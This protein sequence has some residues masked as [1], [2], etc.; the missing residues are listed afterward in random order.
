[1]RYAGVMSRS[2]HEVATRALGLPEEERL[3][4]A[5]ELIDS[6][7]GPADEEWERAWLDELA[8]RQAQGT[9]GARPW[10]EVRS[11]ILRRL[12]GS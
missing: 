9:E 1:M 6:V 10:S 3:A 5:A 2:A 7:E 12:G 8:R 4:L 11:R